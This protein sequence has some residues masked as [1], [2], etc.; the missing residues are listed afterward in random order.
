MVAQ[1]TKAQSPKSLVFNRFSKGSEWDRVEMALRACYGKFH[2]R[3][4]FQ[5]TPN[6]RALIES[7]AG[8]V[9]GEASRKG[10]LTAS[11]PN[12][13]QVDV[14]LYINIVS[15][16]VYGATKT[17]PASWAE[18]SRMERVGIIIGGKAIEDA[19]AGWNN[20]VRLSSFESAFQMLKRGRLDA[21][22]GR[23]ADSLQALAQA[24][25][26]IGDFPQQTVMSFP[27]FHYLHSKHEALVPNVTQELRRMLGSR[28][29]VVDAWKAGS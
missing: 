14:P 22:V 26:R 6:E 11:Y 27:L 24:Q 2:I 12:L 20:I 23:R 21:F 3:L 13:R 4:E 18:L 29:A 16:Y 8:R 15:A 1:G 10:G 9:D 28:A 19:T 7:N 5:E 25:L 17:A